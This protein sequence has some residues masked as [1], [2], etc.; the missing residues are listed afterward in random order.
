MSLGVWNTN[1]ITR[2][3]KNIENISKELQTSVKL[4][5]LEMLSLFPKFIKPTECSKLFI[6]NINVYIRLTGISL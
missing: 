1:L 4:F 5:P 3:L 2:V 6:L